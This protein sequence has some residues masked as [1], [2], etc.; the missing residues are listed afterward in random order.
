VNT[1]SIFS[2]NTYSI[3]S[4]VVSDDP[5]PKTAMIVNIAITIGTT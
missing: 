4:V 5:N 1:G 2:V 3:F